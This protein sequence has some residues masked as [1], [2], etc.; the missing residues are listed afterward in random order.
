MLEE[1]IDEFEAE[2]S[3]R[4]SSAVDADLEHFCPKWD[5]DKSALHKEHHECDLSIKNIH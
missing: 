5:P 4:K 2:I 1:Q 3:T